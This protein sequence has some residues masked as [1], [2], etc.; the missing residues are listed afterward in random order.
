[1]D[2]ALTALHNAERKLRRAVDEQR[3]GLYCLRLWSKFVRL[4]DGRCLRCN[5][6]KNLTA[7]H[8][9][10]KSFLK[11][12]QFQTGNGITLCRKCH[13]IFHE[14]FNGVPDMLLPMDAQGGEKIEEICALYGILSEDA[15][16]RGNINDNFYYISD[17][18]LAIFK[19]LQGFS[20]DVKFPGER[21]QQAYLIWR[22]SPNELLNAVFVAN[23]LIP[24]T[25]PILPGITIITG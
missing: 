5:A 21:I 7:H 17:S 15:S 22:Q 10:R 25:D 24:R 11:V 8:I 19:K 18:V 16:I 3:S 2:K 13:H 12:A 20:P 4:R 14:G 9:C 6:T 1:M 23:G